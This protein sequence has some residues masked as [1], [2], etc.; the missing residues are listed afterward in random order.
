VKKRGGTQTTFPSEEKKLPVKKAALAGLGLKKKKRK[1]GERRYAHLK[2][3]QGVREKRRRKKGA[4]R[5]SS[6]LA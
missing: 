1:G 5:G 3:K 6:F 4:R 2:K